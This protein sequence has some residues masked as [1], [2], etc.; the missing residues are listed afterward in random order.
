MNTPGIQY[1][2]KESAMENVFKYPMIISEI[3]IKF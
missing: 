2:L 3:L 1:S